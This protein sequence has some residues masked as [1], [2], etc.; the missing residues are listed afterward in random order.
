MKSIGIAG[1]IGV[2]KS[3]ILRA[4]AGDVALAHDLGGA[5]VAFDAEIGR[6][7]V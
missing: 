7:H 1:A 4:L 3:S 6:A 2:G 5:V